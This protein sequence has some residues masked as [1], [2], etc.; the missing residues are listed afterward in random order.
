MFGCQIFVSNF[1]FGGLYGYSGGNA[2][3]I[4]K[5]PPLYGVSSGP[6]IYPFQCLKSLLTIETLTV[7][8][9]D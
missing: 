5:K 3:S 8:F 9:S 6:S 1:I 2:I 4:W 7:D